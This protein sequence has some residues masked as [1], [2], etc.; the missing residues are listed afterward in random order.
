MTPTKRKLAAAATDC[1]QHNQNPERNQMSYTTL[2]TDTVSSDC[3]DSAC[4]Q[5]G[6]AHVMPAGME[7][8]VHQILLT[9]VGLSKVDGEDGWR[10]WLAT[11]QDEYSDDEAALLLRDINTAR[12]IMHDLNAGTATSN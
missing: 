12:A 6:S 1:E 10:M 5:Y 8:A 4:D 9:H 2:A 11:P 3:R 7:P